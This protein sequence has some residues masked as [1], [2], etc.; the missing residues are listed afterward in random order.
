MLGENPSQP[1]LFQM[2]DLE[3]LVP[4]DHRL[5]QIDA[6]LD[7]SFLREALADCY[8]PGRGRPS[9]DPEVAMRMMILGALYDLSDRELCQEVAMHAGFRWFCRLNFHDPVPDHSTLS[10]LR[11]ERWAGSDVFTRLFEEV[12]RRCI[13]AGMVSGR[14][15]SVDGTQIKA[16]ASLTSWEPIADEDAGDD[17][18]G[19]APPADGHDAGSEAAASKS[20]GEPQRPLNQTHCSRTDPDARLYRKGPRQK[21]T[22]S[23]LVNDL[24][25]TK[26]RVVLGRK[27][28]VA[29]RPAEWETGLLLVDQHEAHHE[30][31]GLQQGV[32]VLT[33]DKGYGSSGFVADILDRDI[34]PHIPLMSGPE[35]EEVPQY[36][37]RTFNLDHYRRRKQKIRHAKARNAVRLAAKD[38]AYE[39]SRKLRARSEH[40][41]AEAKNRH[42]LGLARH[43]GLTKVDRHSQMIATVQN[44]KRLGRHLHRQSGVAAKSLL[45]S[46][47]ALWEALERPFTGKYFECSPFPA[48]RMLERRFT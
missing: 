20:E 43:R 2:V 48:P 18:E 44:L 26:S 34:T 3:E 28:S 22:P 24:I 33:A 27:V 46:V 1:A 21:A 45:G 47:I 9:V 41:F 6:A 16:N 37:K 8:T 25:D 10:R 4:K 19:Q 31:L 11:N 32:E 39:V 12:L 14:H 23:Y 17:D 36:K 7:L 40:V 30:Q 13:S 29:T 35:L 15:V 5:R 38:H 42:G